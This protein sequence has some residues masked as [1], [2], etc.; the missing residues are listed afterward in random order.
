ML[1]LFGSVKPFLKPKPKIKVPRP[2]N[3]VFR[4]HYRLTFSIFMVSCILVSSYTY[5]DSSGSAI[6]CM[7]DKGLKIPEKIIDRYCWA[8]STFTLPRHYEGTMHEDFLHFGVGPQNEGDEKIYHAYYQWVPLML[9]LQGLMFYFPHWLWKQIEG[10]RMRHIIV[11]LNAY[12]E[13]DD[14]RDEK[15]TQLA[16]YMRE[17]MKNSKEH[18]SWA[19][20]FFFCEVLNFINVV[21]QIYLTNL[22]LG[23]EFTKYG[24]QVLNFPYEDSENRV[25]PMSRIFPKM[26]KCTFHKYG[27]SGTIQN[28]DALCVLG[29]NIL[30]EKIY[31]FLWFWFIILAVITGFNLVVRII[32]MTC[33]NVRD[34]FVELDSR[35][36]LDKEVKRKNVHAVISRISYSD[37]LILYYL[38]QSMDKRNFGQVIEKLSETLPADPYNP[39]PGKGATASE[40][41]EGLNN[42]Q[43]DE[44]P[45]Y[46]DLSAHSEDSPDG[47]L[48]SKAKFGDRKSVV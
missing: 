24:T 33:H 6:K 41:G 27:G 42:Y 12:I 14:S 2:D 32:Q 26:T 35:G 25:D 44:A 13:N 17:R 28:H 39:Y 38:A 34:R 48:R 8:T 18:R 10:G 29:M 15:V 22:F 20:K 4:M 43:D 46:P 45:K 30:S 5:I 23:G 36:H 21:G 37:W 40:E 3:L 9:F 1:G 47:T 16:E 19:M 11:G 7:H 31:I